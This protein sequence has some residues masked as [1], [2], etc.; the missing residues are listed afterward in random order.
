MTDDLRVTSAW[1]VCDRCQLNLTLQVRDEHP[2][3]S[4]PSL[5]E[6]DYPSL[7]CPVC[8]DSV[9]LEEIRHPADQPPLTPPPVPSPDSALQHWFPH[10]RR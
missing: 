9:L 1:G 8:G 2:A 6:W 10:A 4:L 5:D 3:H 7:R